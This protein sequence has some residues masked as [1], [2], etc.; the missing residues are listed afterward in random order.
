MAATGNQTLKNFVI[1]KPIRLTEEEYT[2]FRTIVLREAGIE[3]GS[4]KR[5]MLSNR[6][7]KR[8]RQLGIQTFADYYTYLKKNIK[9]ELLHFIDVVTTNESYFYRIPRQF[10]LLE[11]VVLPEI[12]QTKKDKTLRIWSAG[13]S[14]GE[15]PYT[16]AIIIHELKSLFA[17]WN[18]EIIATDISLSALA[19][20][21]RALYCKR[22]IN[23]IDT[24]LLQK[25]FTKTATD[26]KDE[27]SLF[28]NDLTPMYQLDE[29]IMNMVTFKQLN[30]LKDTFFRNCDIILCRNVMIYFNGE[31]QHALIDKF[32][33]SMNEYSWLFIGHAESLIRRKSAF[34]YRKIYNASVYI[35]N[36]RERQ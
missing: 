19:Y 27:E 4:K 33:N 3:L 6:L 9:V 35:K 5:T 22:K 17:E 29:A 7:R 14:T 28:F 20:A 31:T 25:Y 8:I 15:E 12:I 26:K 34:Q 2:H 18:V 1:A 36:E 32:Y 10:T 24:A 21:R 11:K 16:I 13:C 30:L 23:K